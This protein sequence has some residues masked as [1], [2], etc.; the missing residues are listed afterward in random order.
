METNT[1]LFDKLSGVVEADET[2]IEASRRLGR[3]GSAAKAAL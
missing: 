3:P 2:F 1:S